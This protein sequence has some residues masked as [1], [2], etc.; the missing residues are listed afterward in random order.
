[1]YLKTAKFSIDK[2]EFHVKFASMYNREQIFEEVED[3]GAQQAVVAYW[4]EQQ[5]KNPDPAVIA[6][7]WHLY[8]WDRALQAERRVLLT[9]VPMGVLAGATVYLAK[10]AFFGW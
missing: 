5:K 10:V 6:T 1:M 4:E 3:P 7:G 8:W 2:N 9:A